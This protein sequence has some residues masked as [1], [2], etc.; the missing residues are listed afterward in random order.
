MSQVN[1]KILALNKAALNKS[2][3]THLK[4]ET[5]M[6]IM[7]EKNLPINFESVSKLS[8]ISKTW[9]YRQPELSNEIINLR[10]KTGKIK[11]VIDQKNINEKKDAK[12]LALKNK[13][14]ALKNKIKKLNTQIE[15]IY[16]ELYKLKQ[17]NK[18]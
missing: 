18:N 15:A 17:G 6:R 12:I 13:N 11:R 9:L 3:N 10:N 4:V 16:G 5:V 8:G 1:N 14:I 2:K 7:K